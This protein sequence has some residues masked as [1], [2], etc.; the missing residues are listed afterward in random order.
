MAFLSSRTTHSKL[1]RFLSPLL[2]VG[3]LTPSL[4]AC[5]RTPSLVGLQT[6]SSAQIRAA[7]VAIEKKWN[8]KEAL[9]T[10]QIA[11][12]NNMTWYSIHRR[13]QVVDSI[14]QTQTN[15]AYQFLVSELDDVQ[16]LRKEMAHISAAEAQQFE[17]RL[18][19]N[20]DKLTPEKSEAEIAKER[21]MVKKAESKMGT[22]DSTKVTRAVFSEA[23]VDEL[24]QASVNGQSLTA[25]AAY[26]GSRPRIITAIVESK[27]VKCIGNGLKRIG[28]GIRQLPGRIKNV[29]NAIWRKLRWRDN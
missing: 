19:D 21:A 11:N 8:D 17:E 20:I 9:A 22:K 2:L 15:A 14:A 3:L 27:L 13:M 4:S 29:L 12:Y 18:I 16:E 25:S 5:N 7:A 26:V 24:T 1:V 10:K 28:N 6:S 23:I